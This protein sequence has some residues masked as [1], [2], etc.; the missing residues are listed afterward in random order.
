MRFILSLCVLIGFFGQ[1][2]GQQSKSATLGDKVLFSVDNEHEIGSDEFVYMYKKNNFNNKGYSKEDIEEYL[3]LYKIFK[4]KIFE[5]KKLGYDTTSA[6][7]EEYEK[8]K[9]QLTE[10]YLKTNQINDSLINEAYERLK[11]KVKAAHIL[12]KC[13]QN[14]IPEDTIIAYNRAVQF[15][16][17]AIKN[18]NFSELAISNSDDPSAKINGGDL[19]YFS[20]MHMVYPFESAAYT[21][22]VGAI[23]APVRTIFG[24]HI[25][26]VEAKDLNYKVEVAHI[27]VR[28]AKGE[29]EAAKN[30]IFDIQDQ[31]NS[32]VEW[33]LLCKQFSEDNNT[34]NNGGKIAPFGV[35][36]MP[37]EFQN[38][39]FSLQQEDEYS[40][41][42][43]TPYGWHIVKFIGKH[44]IESFEKMKG[45]I[46]NRI[47]RDERVE[48]GKKALLNRLKKENEFI[49]L[50]N[51]NLYS[52]FDDEL[53]RGNWKEEIKND[54][55]LFTING[56]PFKLLEFVAFAK[57]K[58]RNTTGYSLQ[59]YVDLL[60]EQFEEQSIIDYEKSVLGEKYIDY[61]MLVN[62]Y[63]EGIMLFNL[64]D[65]KVWMK[66][67]NDTTGLQLF[68]KN[69]I[70]KYQ[71]KERAK[72]TIY[73]AENHQIIEELVTMLSAEN[74]TEFSKKELEERYNQNSS[75]T[76]QIEE[77]LFEKG[78]NDILSKVN[79]SLGYQKVEVDG[80][81]YL[82]DIEEIVPPQ[83][84]QL[85]EIKGL[86][87][88]DYQELL[89]KEW[90]SELKAKYSVKVDKR[91][92]K[93]V[94]KK[95]EK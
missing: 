52:Y 70:S 18:N 73:S 80:R 37:L 40:D 34:K 6:F 23:S 12:I 78:Q 93:E 47:K 58:Q 69:N 16:E 71:W 19:G 67:A 89:E 62:E 9:N 90:I 82:V 94:I 77:N 87:I 31:L 15:R 56:K 30:K 88:A 38:T 46:E 86:V 29:E 11:L 36:Q 57:D 91:T 13:D 92:L 35:G 32:G 48:I 60:Y 43:M 45:Q 74:S 95:I 42:F 4:L 20:S 50:Y 85:N 54:A 2:N 79:W 28:L 75:L 44:D 7:I 83:R 53:L 24:Y 17:E 59:Q 64:M 81:Y 8:Y 39:A 51:E 22:K 5:A 41:P 21:T 72:T 3:E 68:Y 26:K 61:K 27:M 49:K 1:S 66:A 55:V 25:I 14:A 84:K 10:N 33:D 76:L 65:D 63:Q